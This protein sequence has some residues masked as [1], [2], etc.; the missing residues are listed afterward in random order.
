MET[1]KLLV[2]GRRR[3]R[4]RWLRWRRRRRRGRR[5]WRGWRH[6][7]LVR[8]RGRWRQRVGVEVVG[9]AVAVRVSGALCRVGQAV[10]VR[11]G[12]E[13]VGRAIS[14]SVGGRL[15]VRGDAIA[16]CVV[17]WSWRWRARGGVQRWSALRAVVIAVVAVYRL[18]HAFTCGAQRIIRF[19]VAAG[20]SLDSPAAGAPHCAQVSCADGLD[21]STSECQLVLR[22]GDDVLPAHV[23]NWLIRAAV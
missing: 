22:G 7:V 1:P 16:V 18:V 17:R 3:G 13:V 19:A 2:G 9:R 21:S 5:R 6:R 15:I 23:L 8:R 11:V 10:A 14:I 20:R 4:R 12:V